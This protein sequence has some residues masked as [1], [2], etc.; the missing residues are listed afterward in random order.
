[1]CCHVCVVEGSVGLSPVADN[2]VDG[3]VRSTHQAIKHSIGEPE[4]FAVHGDEASVHWAAVETCS[5]AGAVSDARH[6]AHVRCRAVVCKAHLG[7]VLAHVARTTVVTCSSVARDEQ[8]KC[9]EC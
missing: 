4:A 8:R 9:C 5:H 1:M 7:A 6:V 2:H 3:S